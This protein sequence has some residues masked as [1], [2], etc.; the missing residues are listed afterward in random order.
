VDAS[1]GGELRLTVDRKLQQA[2]AIHHLFV[3]P[4]VGFAWKE[5]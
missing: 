2:E 3:L 1:G 4:I 5:L